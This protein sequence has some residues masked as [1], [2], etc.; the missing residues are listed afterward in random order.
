MKSRLVIRPARP[1]DLE[2]LDRIERRS[3]AVDRF[4][5]RNLRR[6]LR[7]RTAR[8]AVAES[9]GDA[10]AYVAILTRANSRIARLY[11]IAVDPD[12]RRC[13]LA[14]ALIDWAERE[15]RR[16][17]KERLRLELR[18]SNRA[19]L[20]LYERAGFT[21]LERRLGYYDDGEDAV[22]MELSLEGR[23]FGRQ[24]APTG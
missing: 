23:G 20:R 19:A 14:E 16:L 1:R 3:F 21:F 12:F 22:R 10:A 6:L 15:S 9:E 2:P 24:G 11:S 5:R 18:P 17:G 13:G 8:I 7:S 4:P